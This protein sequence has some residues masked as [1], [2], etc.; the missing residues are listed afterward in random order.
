MKFEDKICHDLILMKSLK[1]MLY[2]RK[3]GVLDGAN[4]WFKF[5]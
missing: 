2:V 5:S 1:R 3:I 4:S